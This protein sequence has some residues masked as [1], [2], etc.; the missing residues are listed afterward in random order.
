[1]IAWAKSKIS[2]LSPMLRKSF[3]ILYSVI[4]NSLRRQKTRILSTEFLV[5]TSIP[6]SRMSSRNLYWREQLKR[7]EI[8][9]AIAACI[10]EMKFPVG[11]NGSATIKSML[12]IDEFKQGF[13]LVAEKTSSFLSGQHLGHY[14]KYS[15]KDDILC[16][17][18]SHHGV[19]I[20]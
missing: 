7:F 18:Y 14:Y 3:S 9:S 20:L 10:S 8:N 1:M 2:A 19:I 17:V 5:S 12:T 16:L 6:F 15:L 11:E 13:K 4:V